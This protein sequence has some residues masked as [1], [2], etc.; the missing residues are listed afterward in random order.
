M[1]RC[2]HWFIRAV[3]TKLGVA[4]PSGR[5]EQEQERGQRKESEVVARAHIM[6]YR[7]RAC[8]SMSNNI[9][10]YDS[11]DLFGSIVSD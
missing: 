5:G 10:K 8:E 9:L 4:R 2:I 1:F 7:W 6:M 3:S 11:I